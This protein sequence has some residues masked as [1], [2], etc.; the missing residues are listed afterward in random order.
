MLFYKKHRV[1]IFIF[2][3]GENV[4]SRHPSV[5]AK[6]KNPAGGKPELEPEQARRAVG[7]ESQLAGCETRHTAS[8]EGYMH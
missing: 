4:I 2:N 7:Q 8:K 3:C 5:F 1:A 6:P